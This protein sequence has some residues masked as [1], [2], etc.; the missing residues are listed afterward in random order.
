MNYWRL[1]TKTDCNLD[2]VAKLIDHCQKIV[3]NTVLSYQKLSGGDISQSL[4]LQSKTEKYFLKFNLAGHADLMFGAEARGLELIAEQ[5]LIRTPRVLGHGKINGTGFLLLEYIPNS[6]AEDGFWEN[7]GAALA[8]LHKKSNTHFGWKH[9]NY[10]GSL[11]QSNQQHQSWSSFYIHERLSPQ[12]RLAID[13]HRLDPI[14]LPKFERLFQL[15]PELCPSEPPALI[16]G[17]LWSGN[18]LIDSSH[19]PVLI[20]PAV[21]YA[22]REMDLAMTMLFGGFDEAFYR[23]YQN[24]Y[25]LEP[26]L[27]QRLKIYQLYYLLVH[28]NLFGGAYTQSVI[29]IINRYAQITKGRN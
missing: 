7:F 8:G 3:Q 26:G 12:L 5:K 17:D 28:V 1:S 14:L 15:L 4:L 18:F 6:Q 21:C 11:P 9:S 20:D 2:P 27:E 10:I 25:P 24:T 13:H 19:K 29:D 23:A 22:Q 16:H